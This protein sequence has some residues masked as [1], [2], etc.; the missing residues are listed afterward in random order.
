MA[1]S[2]TPLHFLCGVLVLTIIT[3]STEAYGFPKCGSVNPG[4]KVMRLASCALAAQDEFAF[5][6]RRCCAQ[7]KKLEKDP[8]CLCSLLLSNAAERYGI[9]PEIAMTIPK[10][11]NIADR[12]V[13]YKCGD[14]KLP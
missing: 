9:D 6:S 4:M 10:L 1:S 14:Y 7:V 12:P 8:D 3:R 11:C 2:M 13:G 5:V